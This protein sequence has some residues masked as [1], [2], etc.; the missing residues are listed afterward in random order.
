[1]SYYCYPQHKWTSRPNDEQNKPDTKEDILSGSMYMKLKE[2][3]NYWIG[4]DVRT[5][6]PLDLLRRARIDKEW[7]FRWTFWRNRNGLYL[8]PDY[9][10]TGS[11]IL[12]FK[13]VY[14]TV[15]KLCL[16]NK[17]RGRDGRHDNA[18]I[19]CRIEGQE[20]NK[21]SLP[22]K[23]IFFNQAKNRKRKYFLLR[24][25]GQ[26]SYDALFYKTSSCSASHHAH[27]SQ[28]LPPLLGN[29]IP[30]TSE[31]IRRNVEKVALAIKVFARLVLSHCPPPCPALPVP[32]AV[33][34]ILFA[35]T[36]QNLSVTLFR[37]R[38]A[39]PH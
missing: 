32:T 30:H 6:A 33:L 12:V 29:W 31:V 17:I 34:H 11:P 20:K 28:Q 25:R 23:S 13:F 38:A 8:N 4:I 16:H 1:M 5:G 21:W 35:W 27:F 22:S 9:C 36:F 15:S 26:H 2:S 24:I 14:F 39:L 37:D 3:Q 19:C 7:G 10:Y 18:V